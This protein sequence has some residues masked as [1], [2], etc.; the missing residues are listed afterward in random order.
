MTTTQLNGGS[1][2]ASWLKIAHKLMR[3]LL[4]S[5]GTVMKNVIRRLG[6]ALIPA[7]AALA[8]SALTPAYADRPTTSPPRQDTGSATIVCD[9]AGDGT[10]GSTI[11]YSPTIL[12]PPNHAVIPITISFSDVADNEGSPLQIKVDAITSSQGSASTGVGSVG[13]GIE[14]KSPA[15]V[16]VGLTAE[17]DGN[18]PRGNIYTID[19][20]CTEF[21][22]GFTENASR[23]LTVIV[24]HDMG[25]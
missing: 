21:D 8:L 15:V 17:R 16:T 12:W 9:T 2:I 22:P 11:T 18:D 7:T 5:G 4:L 3:K 19:V 14:S 6:I 13:K 1:Y 20:T 23:A 10:A 25:P 24:P